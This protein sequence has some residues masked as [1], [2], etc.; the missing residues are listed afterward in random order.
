MNKLFGC[1][2][3]TLLLF[4]GCNS[5]P[6]PKTNSIP[7]WLLN[8]NQN[9]KL[10]AVGS[11]MR[12]YDQ[13]RSTQRKLAITRALDELSLQQGVKVEMNLTKKESYKNGNGTTK[14]DVDA[15][16]QTSATITAHIEEVYQD[17]ISGE[18]FIWMVID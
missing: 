5:Q 15:N 11:S 14:I 13:K 9:S 7:S 18:L 4:T 17:N 10:G 1:V 2:L 16:Y 3:L 8:P 12:T 6:V